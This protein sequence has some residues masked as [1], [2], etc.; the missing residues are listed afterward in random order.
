MYYTILMIFAALLGL[1]I[2]VTAL[3]TVWVIWHQ[4][5]SLKGNRQENL[6]KMTG[7]YLLK[8]TLLDYAVL[9][10][11]LSGILFLF[12]DLL[13]VMRDKAFYPSYHYRYLLSGFVFSLLAMIFMYIRFGIVLSLFR[14]NHI[15]FSKHHDEPTQA[16][17]PK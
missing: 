12:A 8:W 11:F 16:D 1:L 3:F 15:V 13:A 7:N 2:T 10:L 14:S 9:L 4:A 6:T 5:K 17:H